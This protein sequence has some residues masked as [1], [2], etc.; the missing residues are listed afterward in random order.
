MPDAPQ[1]LDN[2]K[3][4]LDSAYF[5]LLKVH[6]YKTTEQMLNDPNGNSVLRDLWAALSYL[7]LHQFVQQNVAREAAQR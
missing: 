4:H 1:D 6:S 7:R 2:A 5:T 3:R